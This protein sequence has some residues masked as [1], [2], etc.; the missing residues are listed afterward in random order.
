M[1]AIRKDIEEF[2]AQIELKIASGQTYKEIRG[3]LHSQG[4]RISKNT[5]STRCSAW[6]ATRRRII[7]Y[8]EPALAAAVET[9]FYTTQRDDN[10]I[11]LD[12]TAQGL[13]TTQAQ[14]KRIRL[15][16]K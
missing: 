10:T 11:T 5:F 14:V 13:Y 16:H 4:V 6:G 15:A 7:P 8:S 3:W 1:P 2:R 9:A 12:V